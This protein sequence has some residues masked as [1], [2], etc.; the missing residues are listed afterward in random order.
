MQA[1]TLLDLY[2]TERQCDS[3]QRSIRTEIQAPKV[4]NQ[5]GQQ[6]CNLITIAAVWLMWLKKFSFLT[7]ATGPFG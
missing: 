4:L 7:F 1:S 5:H 2:G 6:T 3:Q